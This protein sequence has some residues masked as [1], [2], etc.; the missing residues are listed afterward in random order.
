MPEFARH[1]APPAFPLQTDQWLNTP[2]PIELGTLRGKVVLLHAFQMLCP[3]C[4]MYGLPQ[5]ERVHR[6]FRNQDVAVIGLHTVFEH[7][8]VMGW[9]A[10]QVFTQEYGWSFPIAVD[11]A[12]PDGP[13][14]RTMRAYHFEGT[15]SFALLDRAGRIRL[16]HLGQIDDLILG[17]AIG[18]LLAEEKPRPE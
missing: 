15:P 3:G 14:P 2:A 5:A 18:Q 11:R 12:D 10:L 13:L 1:S 9:D 4:L 8:D 6:A 17:A 16:Q 7:H